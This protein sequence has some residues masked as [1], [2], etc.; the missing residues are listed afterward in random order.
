[1]SESEILEFRLQPVKHSVR[2]VLSSLPVQNNPLT[3]LCCEDS[4]PALAGG[5]ILPVDYYY[6]NVCMYVFMLYLL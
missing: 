4:M 1:M 6:F 2:R 3:R 5:G